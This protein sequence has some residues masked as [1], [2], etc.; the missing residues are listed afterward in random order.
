[1]NR[2][3]SIPGPAPETRSLVVYV[4]LLDLL[5]GIH[6]EWAILDD[7]LV[8]RFTLQHQQVRGIARVEQL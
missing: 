5:L 7:R 3:R 4:R 1:M 6:D 2:I 8:Y